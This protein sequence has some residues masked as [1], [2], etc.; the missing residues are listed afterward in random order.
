MKRLSPDEYIFGALSLYLDFINLFLY[1]LRVVSL[2]DLSAELWK[3]TITVCSS[4][5]RRG[6]RER[7]YA[8]PNYKYLSLCKMCDRATIY[9]S[10]EI[11]S[12]TMV[13]AA[14]ILYAV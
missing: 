5:I 4:M 2:H 3:L 13:A 1:I 7:V 10:D 11:L 8:I 12:K 14:S 9:V 6:T